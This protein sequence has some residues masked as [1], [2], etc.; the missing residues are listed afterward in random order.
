MERP[1][2]CMDSDD[3]LEIW[4]YVECENTSPDTIKSER[5]VVKEKGSETIVARSFH[6]TNEFTHDQVDSLRTFFG[7]EERVREWIF[8][9]ALEGT[10][11]RMFCVQDRW[12]LVTHKKLDA[13]RSRWSCKETFGE[14]F[15]NGIRLL[16]G[17]DNALDDLQQQL[18]K[19]HIYFF[20]IRNNQHNRIVC[21]TFHISKENS[22]LFL[23][24][25]SEK[26]SVPFQFYEKGQSPFAILNRF[27][28]PPKVPEPIG[29]VEALVS[30]VAQVD[31]FVH[32][33]IIGFRPDSFETV[34][35][36]HKDYHQYACVRGNNPNLRFRYLELRNQ[37]EQ[38]KLLYVLY[39]SYSS[40][41]NHY[42]ITLFEI[43]KMIFHYYISR[44]IKNQ[45][46]TLPR[47]E[48]LLLKKCHHWYLNDRKRNRIYTQKIME[49]LNEESPLYLYKMIRRFHMHQNQHPH[50][51]TRSSSNTGPPAPFRF[52][53]RVTHRTA[54]P[55]NDLQ[56]V[57]LSFD[58]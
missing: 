46:I 47:E 49:F 33:G 22:I 17:K 51:K 16:L 3:V 24:H 52:L 41:F 21:Q 4:N 57:P 2:Q 27:E 9:L 30:R 26:E 6:Y 42:E 12:Y 18:P 7:S 50:D 54:T 35:V 19:N 38:V 56:G 53:P 58:L 45:Y 36:L 44:Y 39:P 43:A 15:Q 31:I 8:Y 1:V 28:A 5:G 20:L 10:L 48:Y 55:V 32:Q 25:Y 13:F 37:P 34:K 23:G 11:V 29:T 14:L 40:L